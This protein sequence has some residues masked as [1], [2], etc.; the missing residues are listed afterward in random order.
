V[1]SRG[2]ATPKRAGFHL[3]V[4]KMEVLKMEVLNMAGLNMA[5]TMV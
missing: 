4:L 3:A 5:K 2:N 1:E